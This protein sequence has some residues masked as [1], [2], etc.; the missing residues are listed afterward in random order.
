MRLI[1][2]RLV[3]LA[4]DP[5]KARKTRCKS[6]MRRKMRCKS[7]RPARFQIFPVLAVSGH[8]VKL[9]MQF[10]SKEMTAQRFEK[11]RGATKA[12]IVFYNAK[13]RWRYLFVGFWF[14]GH[15]NYLLCLRAQIIAL[16][17]F[18]GPHYPPSE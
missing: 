12:M 18:K 4:A 13:L 16:I 6:L 9:E 15:L 8:V 3:K 5:R 11:F 2:E 10:S 14:V 17:F 7:G 1:H